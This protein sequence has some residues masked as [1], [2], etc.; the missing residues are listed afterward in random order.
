M[1]IRSINHTEDYVM[2]KNHSFLE[3]QIATFGAALNG[4]NQPQSEYIEAFSKSF[5]GLETQ[6]N[7]WET[8][9]VNSTNVNQDDAMLFP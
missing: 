7:I 6:I 2:T 3:Q 8:F 1:K 5:K 4:G 9:I